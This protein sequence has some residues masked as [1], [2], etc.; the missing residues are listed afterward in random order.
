[1]QTSNI[2]TQFFVYLFTGLITTTMSKLI[3][4][5]NVFAMVTVRHLR[6]YIVDYLEDTCGF[7]ILFRLLNNIFGSFQYIY[8]EHLSFLFDLF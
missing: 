3:I 1:M 4:C 7:S 6:Y 2:H 5:M 8:I